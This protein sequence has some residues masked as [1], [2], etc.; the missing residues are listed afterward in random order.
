MLLLLKHIF[1]KQKTQVYENTV[2]S[3]Y[4]RNIGIDNVYYSKEIC[5]MAN[6][7][8]VRINSKIELLLQDWRS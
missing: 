4:E 1:D 2:P 3:Y 7:E 5:I 8:T 6:H